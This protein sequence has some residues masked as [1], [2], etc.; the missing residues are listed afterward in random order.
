MTAPD[1]MPE[2][3]ENSLHDAGHP[4]MEPPANPVVANSGSM[5]KRHFSR[6]TKGS[7]LWCPGNNCVG[8]R[9]P[10]RPAPPT[11]AA[12]SFGRCFRSRLRGLV[13]HLCH[14]HHSREDRRPTDTAAF[15]ASN[16]GS[17]LS[18]TFV[19][20]RRIPR[21]SRSRSRSASLF[22]KTGYTR[23]SA[24]SPTCEVPTFDRARSKLFCQN[25]SSRSNIRFS[26]LD[27]L[28]GRSECTLLARDQQ[29][30]GRLVCLS[31]PLRCHH[32]WVSQLSS[33]G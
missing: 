30:F 25:R 17:A 14:S 11:L 27:S 6:S 23:V 28:N 16:V 8:Q 2:A 15:T 22:E 4:H 1:R 18:P 12:G 31:N 26:C 20:I 5:P 19:A 21:R 32:Q 33:A 24:S 13:R 29:S 3:F 7:L 9:P 10:C